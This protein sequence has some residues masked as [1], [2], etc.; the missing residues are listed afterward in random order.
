MKTVT[1]LGSAAFAVVVAAGFVY[2]CGP[3]T[4]APA[5]STSS[6]GS[7]GSGGA[8][9]GG[10]TASGGAAG[11]PT[12]CVAI[13]GNIAITDFSEY[14]DGDS[15]TYGDTAR[16]WGAS[17]S[18]TG[19]DFFYANVNEMSLVASI[20]EGVL[21]LTKAIPAGEYA[22]Y[23]LYFG[24]A[25]NDASR[26]AGITFELGGDVGNSEVVV[27]LQQKSNYPIEATKGGCE[28][29]SEAE[30]W[31][32]CTNNFFTLEGT[33]IFELTWDQFV[34]GTPEATCNPVEL[35]GIQFQFNC[36]SEGECP[37]AVTLDNITFRE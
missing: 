1:S 2:G 27:Q 4:S 26:L 28:F 9:T 23:G 20:S 25:C 6:G 12:D 13:P 30:K 14:T 24:P 3:D 37:V 32:E 18:L 5:D 19:G 21:T 10:S 35:L 17:D 11:A 36:G 31:N 29:S 8:A 15:W 7:D 16:Q 22:G 34:G 33:G